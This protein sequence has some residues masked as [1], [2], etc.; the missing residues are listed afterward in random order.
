MT[1]LPGAVAAVVFDCDGLL[2][3]TETCW[4]RAE[5][6][7]FAE[8]GHGFGIAEKKLL[9][10]G[11]LEAAGVAM[12]ARFGRPGEGPALAS[13]LR[14]LVA[15]ELAAGA[16]ALPGALE[17]V[18]TLRERV[19]VAVASNSPRAFVDA[20]LDSA[21][22]TDLFEFVYAAEDVERPKPAPDLYLAACAGLGAEP[23]R[24]VAFEDSRTGVASAR[25]AGMYVIGV[26]S[27]PDTT[28]DTDRT[29]ASLTDDELTAWAAQA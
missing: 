8:H 29:Y 28:L 26:P 2:V 17:L 20:A 9:I 19:P 22:L 25:A 23:A 6:A 11:T 5:T 15:G 13:R 24:S 16:D 14:D 21:G 10:G 18:K 12:A 27:I 7:I 3:D 1:G 4:T